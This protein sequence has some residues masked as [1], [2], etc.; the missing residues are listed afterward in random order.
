M[1]RLFSLSMAG[2]LAIHFFMGC[3][4]KNTGSGSEND[5]LVKVGDHILTRAEL[6]E[7]VPR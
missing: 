2:L 3:R 6:N 5:V 4:G 1:Y 7:S